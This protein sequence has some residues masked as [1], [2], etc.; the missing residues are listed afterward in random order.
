M[1]LV[2]KT[3]FLYRTLQKLGV[4]DSNLED[5]YL[6]F[7]NAGISN[8]KD[9]NNHL[10]AKLGL[11]YVGEIDES[12]LEDVVDYY[13][14]LKLQ[15]SPT[16]SKVLALLKEYKQNPNKKLYDDIINSQL[17]EVLLTACTYKL[18]HKDIILGDLVQICNMGL[19]KAVEKFDV[20][21]HLTFDTYLN[22][23]IMDAINNE[24]TQGEKNG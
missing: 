17:K 13:V 3:D 8:I 16:K 15:K 18:R 14:D 20:N 22:Y 4:E 9:F 6:S 2:D 11:D 23:W 5:V 1:I 7:A 19:M 21:S 12:C 24:F 10:Q